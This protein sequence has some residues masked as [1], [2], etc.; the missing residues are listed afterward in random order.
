M[1][2]L[3]FLAYIAVSYAGGF[4]IG[5]PLGFALS[6]LFT[7]HLQPF[8]ARLNDLVPAD[9][10]TATPSIVEAMHLRRTSRALVAMG[11]AMGCGVAAA[12][13]IKF[14]NY[15]PGTFAQLACL[16]AAISFW[17]F[18]VLLALPAIAAFWFTLRLLGI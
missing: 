2:V 5:M 14:T 12:L 4:V 13:F 18:K 9:G 1:T 6:M 7:K 10:A 3:R 15:S 16:V 17:K 11:N 8:S